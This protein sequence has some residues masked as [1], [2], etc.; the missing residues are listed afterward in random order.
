MIGPI[1]G[2]ET[3]C[4]ETAAAVV[5]DGHIYSNAIF[6][7][8]EHSLYGGV[9]PE[10][11]SRNHI[12]T[13]LPVVDQALS[14]AD[15]GLDDLGGIAC[16]TGTR[17]GGLPAR[18]H[19]RGQRACTGFGVASCGRASHRRTF[20]CRQYGAS[21]PGAAFYGAGGFGRAYGIDLCLCMG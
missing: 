14:E 19:F 21:R 17:P 15:L 7:Q 16:D 10:L 13:L 1:L 4:D 8:T 12:R 20:I 6:S 11:A 18:G 5:A 9:V 3:S 2:I